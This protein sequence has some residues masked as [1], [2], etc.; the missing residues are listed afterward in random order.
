MTLLMPPQ[1]IQLFK[2]GSKSCRT[3]GVIDTAGAALVVS[4][5]LLVPKSAIL[6]SNI[7]KQALNSD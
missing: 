3:S 1:R 5:T 4:L 2:L 7:C 6:K